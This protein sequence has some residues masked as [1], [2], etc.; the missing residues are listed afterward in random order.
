VFS[1]D[2]GGLVKQIAVGLTHPFVSPYDVEEAEGGWLVACRDLHRVEFVV[3]GDSGPGGGGEW[4]SL[5]KAGRGDG[6]FW[7]PTTMADVPGLGLVVRDLY[8]IQVFTTPEAIAMAAMSPCRVA[9]MT[10]VARSVLRRRVLLRQ[11]GV[12]VGEGVVLKGSSASRGRC[13]M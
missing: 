8:R 3:D 2:D 5:G 6:E 4:P 11:A 9:W 13:V 12:S 1:V 10:V 7:Y